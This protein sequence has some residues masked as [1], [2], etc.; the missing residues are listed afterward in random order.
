MSSV[1]IVNAMPQYGASLMVVNNGTRVV[2]H[3]ANIVA[4]QVT[5]VIVMKLLFFVPSGELK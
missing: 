3:A 5:G 1:T 2:S 4:I